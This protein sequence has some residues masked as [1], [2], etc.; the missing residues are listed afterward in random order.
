MAATNRTRIGSA[1]RLTGAFVTVWSVALVAHA[2]WSQPTTVDYREHGKLTASNGARSD[3]L[4]ASVAISGDTVVATA[5]GAQNNQG[6]VYLFEKPTNGWGSLRETARLTPSAA[7]PGVGFGASVAIAGDTVVVG[8]SSQ[9]PGTVYV[10]RKPATGWRNMTETARLTASDGAALDAFGGVVAID[11]NTIV[12]S[13]RDVGTRRDHGALYVFVRPAAGWTNATETAKLT[14]SDGTTGDLLGNTS[15][16]VDGSTIVAGAPETSV[17]GFIDHGAVYVFVRPAS[18][19]ANGTEAAKL[20]HAGGMTRDLLGQSVDIDGDL[21]VAASDRSDAF[22]F[23][24][25]AAGWRVVPERARLASFDSVAIAGRLIVGG[26]P[27]L[28]AGEAAVFVAPASGWQNASPR[29]SIT[30]S[31][32]QTSDQLGH[33][34]S[35]D[36]GIMAVGARLAD[37][38]VADTGAVYLFSVADVHRIGSARPGATVDLDL[39]APAD[40]GRGYQVV[41]SL[42]AG[43]TPIAGRRLPIGFDALFALSAQNALPGIFVAFAGTLDPTGGARSAIR[44]PL[45]RALVGQTLHVAFVTVGGSPTAIQSISRSTAFEIKP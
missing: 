37:G 34:V 26:R 20:V 24:R 1:K 29:F 17:G 32:G 6:V 40:A 23:E 44:L 14:A 9:G 39:I 38:T 18:G 4:G 11:G 43:A 21:V 45:E 12:A 31:D 25:P 5:A 15:I 35:I 13:S 27:V 28:R 19:W 22:V 42:T 16:A 33:A 10:F 3:L 8:G 30:A 2:A 7:G 41:T 36:G